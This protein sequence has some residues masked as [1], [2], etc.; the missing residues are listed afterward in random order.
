MPAQLQRRL[1]LYAV[2]T[3]SVGAMI[4]SGIFVLPGLAFEVGGPS[5]IFAFMLAG[6]IVLPAALAQAEMATAMPRAG[7]AYLYIDMAMGPLMGTVAGIGV[8]FSLVFK[9]AFALDGVGLYLGLFT[10]IDLHTLGL[11]I[12]VAL[13]IINLVGI[14]ESGTLQATLV[15]VVFAILLVFIGGGATFVESNF[16]HPFSPEG[17]GGLLATTALVFVSFAGVTKVASLAEEVA[18]PARTLPV[19]II[20]SLLVMMFVYP[21]VTYVMVGVTPAETLAGDLTPLATASA[22]VFN[23]WVVTIIE[24]VGVLALASMA[25]AGL[26]ASSRYPF[27]MARRRLAP[28]ILTRVWKRSGTPGLSVIVTG[29]V[30]LGLVAF[31]PVLELAKLASAFQALVLAL[32]CFAHIAFR[33]SKLWWYRPKFKA[34]GYPLVDILGAG[35]CL[36]LITQLGL[37]AIAGAAG[38]IVG[39][40]VW[41]QVYGRSRALKESAFRESVREQGMARLLQLTGEALADESRK[42][43]VVSAT[44]T[45]DAWMLRIARS[46]GGTTSDS[47]PIRVVQRAELEERVSDYRPD[48]LVSEL[49]ADDSHGEQLPADVDVALVTGTP[50]ESIETIAVLGSGGPFDVL[51]ISVATKL[52]EAKGATLRFVHVLDPTSSRA[53]IRTLEKFH[54]QLGDLCAVPTESMVIESMDL[55][56]ALASAVEDADL[57]VMGSSRGHHLFTDLIDRIVQR[58]SIPVL[59]VRVAEKEEPTTFRSLLDR[60]LTSRVVPSAVRRRT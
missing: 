55:V 19:A 53:Q 11:L 25:N 34:P 41:Y 51:K 48:L 1:G 6:L 38:I 5:V 43:V 54:D 14:K 59:L 35:A 13:L 57:A 9:A 46:L 31:L 44:D 21:A 39:G 42:V 8:W 23:D 60:V 17:I 33:S 26:L 58:M 22:Q 52:A 2:F 37:E 27:A 45:Y 49:T 12:G 16:Y 10:E 4:G 30:L 47:E 40:L 50:G 20:S 24:I 3:V 36:V 56:A 15:T 18:N 29:V 7:G 32:V 28:S